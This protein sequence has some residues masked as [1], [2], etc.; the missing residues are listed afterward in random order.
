[1]GCKGG[2]GAAVVACSLLLVLADEGA[3]AEEGGLAVCAGADGSGGAA[4]TSGLASI[5][6]VVY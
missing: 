2:L 4:G 6:C 1:M 3:C 5:F